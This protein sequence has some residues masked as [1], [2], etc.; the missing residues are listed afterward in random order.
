LSC[1]AQITPPKKGHSEANGMG[2][3]HQQQGKGVL[4]GETLKTLPGCSEEATWNTQAIWNTQAFWNTKAFWNTEVIRKR[5][6]WGCH[7]FNW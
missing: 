1:H 7:W 2:G 3:N 4:G 6:S 5:S